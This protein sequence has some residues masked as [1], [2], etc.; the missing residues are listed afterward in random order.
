MPFEHRRFWY[1]Q[2]KQPPHWY[3]GMTVLTEAKSTLKL[4]PP[5]KTPRTF[6]GSPRLSRT[7][8]RGGSN[9]FLRSV[10]APWCRERE[11]SPHSNGRCNSC[12]LLDPLLNGDSPDLDSS[13]KRRNGLPFHFD[14]VS[15]WLILGFS[16]QVSFSPPRIS[17]F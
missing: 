10:L 8:G 12:V 7:S 6:P 16:A 4:A 14:W 17:S 9:C 1:P 11:G 2:W 5:C 13:I 15:T 3:L